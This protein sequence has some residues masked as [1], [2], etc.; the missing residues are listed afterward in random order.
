[1]DKISDLHDPIREYIINE[2]LENYIYTKILNEKSKLESK[3]DKIDKD[4]NE[5]EYNKYINEL[6]EI[7]E[8]IKKI[9]K[10]KSKNYNNLTYR[11]I[12]RNINGANE[13]ITKSK[14]SFNELIKNYVELLTNNNEESDKVIQHLKYVKNKLGSFISIVPDNS[15]NKDDD[16]KDDVAG[17]P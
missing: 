12:V 16:V 4:K 17:E 7:N 5:S 15:N 10:N 1:M 13:V 6:T 9:D 2:I 14:E 8:N 3:I 11:R